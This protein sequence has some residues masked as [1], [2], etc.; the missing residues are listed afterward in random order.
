MSSEQSGPNDRDGLGAEGPKSLESD[1]TQFA[2]RSIEPGE[3]APGTVIDSYHLLQLIGQGG[4]GEV[5]LA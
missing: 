2:T 5:W 4:M 3:A 1:E